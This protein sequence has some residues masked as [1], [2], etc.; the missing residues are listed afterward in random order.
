MGYDMST[1]KF[2]TL[3]GYKYE[4]VSTQYLHTR[5]SSRNLNKDLHLFLLPLNTLA[6]LRSVI[7]QSDH[8]VITIT[9]IVQDY[10]IH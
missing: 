5:L 10:R 6:W 4:N 2:T 8:K 3:Q 1:E 7:Y 9:T